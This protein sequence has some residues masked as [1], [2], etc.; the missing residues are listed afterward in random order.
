MQGFCCST[1]QGSFWFSQRGKN[2]TRFS[3]S[4]P[5]S[6][7]PSAML[8]LLAG[9]RV[10]VA[11]QDFIPSG[12]CVWCAWCVVFVSCACVMCHPSCCVICD[13]PKGSSRRVIHH[14]I[15]KL[16]AVESINFETV[17]DLKLCIIKPRFLA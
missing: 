11:E 8:M 5:S 7:L 6:I 10:D 1:R 4:D 13:L 12:A 2:K 14:I 3:S 16:R 17:P 9:R 15:M